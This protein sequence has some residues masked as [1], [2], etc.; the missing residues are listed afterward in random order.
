MDKSQWFWKYGYILIVPVALLFF[1]FDGSAER[2]AQD[3]VS[4]AV[5]AA[6]EKI[7]DDCNAEEFDNQSTLCSSIYK[8]K[9]ECTQVTRRCNSLT[10][11][12]FLKSKGF[13]LPPYYQPG[14][15]PKA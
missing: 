15:T 14:Y 5:F 11:Y 6:F 12:D 8:H 9:K 3:N 7:E 1:W 4:L 10:Y 13:E 2:N